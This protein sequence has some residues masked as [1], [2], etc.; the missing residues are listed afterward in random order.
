[1]GGGFSRFHNTNHDLAWAASLSPEKEPEQI[2]DTNLMRP[3]YILPATFQ[4]GKAT[5]FE[6][7]LIYPSLAAYFRGTIGEKE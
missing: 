3:P 5:C 4:F 6:T 7:E 1:M 2:M